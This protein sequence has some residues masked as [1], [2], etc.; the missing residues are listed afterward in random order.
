MLTKEAT[1]KRGD[2]DA[3]EMKW[4]RKTEG[5]QYDEESKERRWQGCS[6]QGGTRDGSEGRGARKLGTGEELDKVRKT[7]D[8]GMQ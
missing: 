3:D 6:G 1:V 5:T 4:T 7:K 2:A 8:E